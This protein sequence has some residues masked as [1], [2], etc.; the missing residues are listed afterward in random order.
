[1]KKARLLLVAI[2]SMAIL[3][4]V[5]ASKANRIIYIFYRSAVV[6]GPC[7]IPTTYFYTT[8]IIIATCS[9]TVR[10]S[11]TQTT[12]ACPIITVYCTI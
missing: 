4:G 12:A 8:R 9:F 6:G 7:S 10:L 5:F 3:G 11:T 1:M 2:F